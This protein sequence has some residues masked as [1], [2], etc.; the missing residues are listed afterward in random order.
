[1]KDR[2]LLVFK[3]SWGSLQSGRGSSETVNRGSPCR[4]AAA[5]IDSTVA[6]LQLR[7]TRIALMASTVVC[8]GLAVLFGRHLFLALH[9][10]GVRQLARH[11][12]ATVA[13]QEFPEFEGVIE[14]QR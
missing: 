1:M 7:L 4:K 6:L 11:T 10:P 14:I 2:L 5:Q 9:S 3:I 13:V 12:P 8:L